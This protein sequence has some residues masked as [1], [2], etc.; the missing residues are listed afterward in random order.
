MPALAA[1]APASARFLHGGDGNLDIVRK[2]IGSFLSS[3][4]AGLDQ[5]A[6]SIPLIGWFSDRL[7]S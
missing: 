2:E 6:V 4:Q 7:A 5:I 1:L 3:E